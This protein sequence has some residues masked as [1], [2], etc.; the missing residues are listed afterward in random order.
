MRFWN[1]SSRQD[2]RSHRD[3]TRPRGPSRKRRLQLESL[4]ERMVLSTY[5]LSEF[6][7][8]GVPVVRETVNSV[9]TNFVN[10]TSPFM[11]NTGSGAT[12]STSWTPPP[13]SPSR[14][15][16]FASD[17][18]NVGNA[19]SV[20]GILAA[21]NIQNPPSFTTLNVNDSADT[22]GADR[23]AEHV[24]LGRRQLGLDHRTGP[25]RDQLQVRRHQQREH[26]DRLG[27]R[28]GQ[29]ARHRRRRPA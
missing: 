23:D 18:V 22:D 27:G 12:R 1:R 6:F 29:R 11:V 13:A 4:E 24:R 17:T 9:T 15:I 25:G 26:H 7:S 16:G 2:D 8:A 14:S 19:G 10:P 3:V 20:Q 21:V 28:H 5:T